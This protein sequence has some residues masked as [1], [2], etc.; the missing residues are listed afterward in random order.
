MSGGYSFVLDC[1]VTLAWLFE[2]EA[3]EYAE[4]ALVKL[5]HRAAIVPN[6]WS[7]E[8]ANILL[9]S[10]KKG[11][12]TP[13]KAS[14]FIDALDLLPIFVDDTT[15]VRALRATFALAESLNLTIYDAT[16]LELAQREKIPLLT[17]D[18]DLLKAAHKV[19]VKTHC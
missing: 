19:G 5:K 15:S 17:L 14:S 10:Q 6:L 13:Y 4:R 9:L 1:S 7:L 8:V 3:S 12:I 11:R 16:Y 18:Q 2:D